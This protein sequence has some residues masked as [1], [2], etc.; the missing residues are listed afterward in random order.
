MRK[1]SPPENKSFLLCPELVNT[2][3]FNKHVKWKFI[4]NMTPLACSNDAIRTYQLFWVSKATRYFISS[5]P[6]TNC[7][8]F[9]ITEFIP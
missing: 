3:K 2:G 4:S 7:H 9:S 1:N 5:D 6:K 8:W